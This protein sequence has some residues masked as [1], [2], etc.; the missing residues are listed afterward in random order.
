MPATHLQQFSFQCAKKQKWA[1]CRKL[2]R[3]NSERCTQLLPRSAVLRHRQP[4]CVFLWALCL[5][6]T[7]SSRQLRLPPAGFEPG[8]VYSCPLAGVSFLAPSPPLK[9]PAADEIGRPDV[10]FH[11][12]NVSCPPV[13]QQ[14]TVARQR[15]R[16]TPEGCMT[17]AVQAAPPTSNILVEVLAEPQ[18]SCHDASRPGIEFCSLRLCWVPCL[19]TP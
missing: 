13:H 11:S 7:V 6:V 3:S 14:P 17:Y 10:G 15:G 19:R 18:H 5:A 4:T 16:K 9:R 8:R 2:N 12:R 1:S